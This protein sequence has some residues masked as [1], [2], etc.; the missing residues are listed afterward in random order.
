[1]IRMKLTIMIVLLLMTTTSVTVFAEGSKGSYYTIIYNEI[2]N[3]SPEFGDEW[4]DWIAKAIL[5]S[6]EKWGVDPLLA[7][8]IFKQES[9][10]SMGST[11]DAGSV[12]IS[13]LVPSTARGLGIN[14]NYPLENIDGGVHYLKI[15]LDQFEVQSAIAAYNAGPNAVREY[16]G[17]PPYSETIHYVKN[18]NSTYRRLLS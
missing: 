1:M 5:S 10:F 2:H 18:I 12:G 8:A 9:E 17:V 15:Q 4:A 13:Q 6:S 7:T 3:T 16:N 14:P 11:S